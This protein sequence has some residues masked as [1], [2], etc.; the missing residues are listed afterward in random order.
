MKNWLGNALINEVLVWVETFI[1]FIPGQTG[2]LLRRLWFARRFK[3]SANL[4]IGRS[5]Q[6]VV[7]RSM[8][9]AGTTLISDRCY[10][11]ADGGSIH[12]GDMTGFNMGAHINAA[13]G[14]SIIIGN[15]CPIGPGVMMR[16]ANHRFSRSDINIQEQGHE[17][18]DIN[19]LKKYPKTKYIA[20]ETDQTFHTHLQ[21]IG[22]NLVESLQFSHLPPVDLIVMSHVLE[23]VANPLAFLSEATRQLR[24]GGA[25]FIEVPCR[26]YE[27]KSLDEPHLLFFDKGP[28]QRL[29][30]Q[31]GFKE[32]RLSYHRVTLNR[33]RSSPLWRAKLLALRSKLIGLG[34][35]SP[36]GRK[37]SG[38]EMLT[39][40]VER[41]IIAPTK[42]HT[43]STLPA[44]W[45]RAVAIK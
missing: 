39:D 18:A 27:H 29:L 16:T 5:C 35:S 6:F 38:M 4:R 17:P 14:G 37:R 15:H 43:E 34:L 7:P 45:L 8:S 30:H 20:S 31:L 33:L 11:N 2:S 19:W 42:A 9:F 36:F 28:M 10:F 1:N 41:A 24:K 12:I 23:H 22:L 26:D 21:K 13:G 44:W 25:L 40:P 32:I 3:S